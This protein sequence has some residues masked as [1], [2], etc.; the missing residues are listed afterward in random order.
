MVEISPEITTLFNIL[1][2]K[3]YNETDLFEVLV[4]RDLLL[5]VDIEQK[6]AALIDSLKEKYKSSKLNSLHK[7]RE[8]KQK[9][10]G[11]NLLRQILRCNGYH[12][13]PIVYSR[14]YCKHSG[15]KIVDRNFKVVRNKSYGE[16]K[17]AKTP[18]NAHLNNIKLG[19]VATQD[20]TSQDE[21]VSLPQSTPQS[22]LES[23]SQN[24]NLSTSKKT[25]I[26][27]I[28]LDL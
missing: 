5:R 13:K 2:M 6:L 21:E 24:E 15:K 18:A 10:P 9:F 28:D 25:S 7:N 20:V 3:V 26:Q 17:Y 8:Q 1:D 14:G 27:I 16:I 4:H 19:I 12:L 11:I 22:T 23:I